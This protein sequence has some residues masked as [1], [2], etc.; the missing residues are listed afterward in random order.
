MV[1]VVEEEQEEEVEDVEVVTE[2]VALEAVA[3]TEVAVVVLRMVTGFVQIPPV[4][5]S[6]LQGETLVTSAVSPD[7]KTQDMVEI[8]DEEAMEVIEGL[9]D[10]EGEVADLGVKWVAGMTSEVINV[11]DLIEAHQSSLALQVISICL[12]LC[13]M[14]YT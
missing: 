8:E 6:T 5:M 4:V 11:T 3:L 9:E 7:Q 12:E 14:L 2:A 13:H 10:V 1:L